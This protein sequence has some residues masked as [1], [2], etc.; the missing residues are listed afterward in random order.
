MCRRTGISV[1]KSTGLLRRHSPHDNPCTGHNLS[2]VP[3]SF[4]PAASRPITTRSTIQTS[5]DDTSADLFY[6]SSAPAP[7][8]SHPIRGAPILKRLPKGLRPSASTV[9]QRLVQNVVRD[10]QNPDHWDRLF[11]FAPACFARPDRE[12][13]SRNLTSLVK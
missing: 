6:T 1:V 12:G 7:S 11:G 10:P 5:A 8:V 3:G 2:P 13:K 4:M 9:L